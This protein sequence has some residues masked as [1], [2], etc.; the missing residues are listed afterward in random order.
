M[1]IEDN[2]NTV[3]DVY[4]K[5]NELYLFW[6]NMDQL[7]GLSQDLLETKIVEFKA[8]ESKVISEGFISPN[9]DFEELM[10]EN[11]KFLVMPV[12]LADLYTRKQ[13]GRL[14]Y[15]NKAEYQYHQFL[16]L[17]SHYQICPK[18]LEDIFEKIRAAPKYQTSR[19]EKI[20]LYKEGREIAD[21]L[22]KNREKYLQEGPAGN[23]RD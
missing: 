4:A 5:Y 1:N 21:E 3:D 22:E 15:L 11:L 17:M 7:E 18:H 13:T 10:P 9:E 16:K 20:R 6:L 19:D 12:I 23:P 2:Q 8:T 14:E